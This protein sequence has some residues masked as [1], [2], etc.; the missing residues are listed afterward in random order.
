MGEVRN[1]DQKARKYLFSELFYGRQAVSYDI[2]FK[3]IIR[4][5][6]VKKIPLKI[7]SGAQSEDLEPSLTILELNIYIYIAGFI[8]SVCVPFLGS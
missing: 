6:E 4:V 5:G 3:R 7:S 8:C 1:G 2:F